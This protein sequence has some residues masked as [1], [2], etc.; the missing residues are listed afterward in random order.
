MKRHLTPEERQVLCDIGYPVLTA[1]GN[2]VNY[3][4]YSYSGAACDGS[5]VVGFNDGITDTGTYAFSTTSGTGVLISGPSLGSTILD[6]DRTA[7]VSMSS[8]PGAYFKCLQ[9]MTG[10]GTVSIDSGGI[11]DDVTYTPGAAD[12][13]VQLLR[14]IPLNASGVEGGITYIYVF[15]GDANC[16]PSACNLVTNGN[17]EN[18]V[19]GSYGDL[20]PG[21]NCW[22]PVNGT[23]TLL[24]TDAAGSP[25]YQVPNYVQFVNG[26][27]H[28]L[29]APGNND[30]VGLWSHHSPTGWLSSSI[31]ELLSVPLDSGQQYTITFWALLG[32]PTGNSL[33]NP[34][35]ASLV[36]TTSPNIGIDTAMA[37]CISNIASHIQFAAGDT[38][39]LIGSTFS[40]IPAPYMPAGFT[41]LAKFNIVPNNFLWQSYSLTFTYAGP[42]NA[43]TLLIQSTFWD[44][45]D[46]GISAIN[47]SN[48]FIAIDDVSIFPTANA[49]PFS[50]NP[51]TIYSTSPSFDLSSVA[52]VCVAGGTFSWPAM[53]VITGSG[54]PK[55][56][57]TTSGTFDP[58]A[59]DSASL[60]TGGSG[61]IP[62]GYTFTS[63]AGCS[64]T[65]YTNIQIINLTGIRAL[66][67]EPPRIYPNPAN[68]ILHIDIDGVAN[69]RLLSIVGS[70][71][72]QGRLYNGPN[73]VSM[74][75]LPSGIYMLEITDNYGQKMITKIIKQ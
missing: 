20:I 15:A 43:S 73:K 5:Q 70:V 14:Y 55:P 7:G 64:Q 23:P 24:S 37:C 61:L 67:K 10:T 29:S 4:N 48:K 11:G 31:Q 39:P 30:Y 72:R 50:I 63:A 2:A 75:S 18:V 6:N 51:D 53:P 33:T 19:P 54:V 47:D 66:T 57:I 25:Y 22:T 1:F 28:P 45:E 46:S 68:D 32:G 3:S 34:A 62:V 42:A 38:Y 49:C 44:D 12:F 36:G 26:V 27:P 59:A 17:F 16:V 58:A 71:L 74:Q 40:E 9:V 41:S 69:Y 65:V 35:Y 52:D 21:L 8:V 60:A 13:G 56:T